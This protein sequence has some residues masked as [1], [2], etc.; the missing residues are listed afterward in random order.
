MFQQ[1]KLHYLGKSHREPVL[2]R[3]SLQNVLSDFSQ[4]K[5]FLTSEKPGKVACWSQYFFSNVQVNWENTYQLSFLC[6]W[7][8][9]QLKLLHTRVATNDVFL[10]ILVLFALV[11]QRH[12][13]IFLGIVDQLRLSGIMFR[14]GPPRRLIWPTWIL[15]PFRQLFASA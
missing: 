8:V 13:R 4:K 9:F 12:V 15:P 3:E 6:T 14:S 10:K 1:S 11:P 2:F 5:D 7:R